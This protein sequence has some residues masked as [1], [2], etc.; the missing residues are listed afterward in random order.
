MS[1]ILI[2][3]VSSPEPNLEEYTPLRQ[4]RRYKYYTLKNNSNAMEIAQITNADPEELDFLVYALSRSKIGGSKRRTRRTRRTRR[5]LRK[6]RK[7]RKSR[8][9]RK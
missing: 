7:S 5:K 6:S 8:K 1:S 2:L 9:Y 4:T 3:P